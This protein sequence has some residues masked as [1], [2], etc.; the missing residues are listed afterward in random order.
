MTSL[1]PCWWTK[2]KDL[3]LAS[4][5]RPPEVVNFSIVIGVS[6][7]WLKTSYSTEDRPQHRELH[8]LLFAKCV[9]EFFYVSQGYE[10]RR[11]VTW[12]LRFIVRK[13]LIV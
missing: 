1:P 11:V 13:D 10:H 12:G 2:T 3:S 7:G 5:A 6:I 4:F 8:A 9:V